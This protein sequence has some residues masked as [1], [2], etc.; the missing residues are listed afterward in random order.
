[1]QSTRQPAPTEE[2]K[3]SVTA[4]AVTFA[5]MRAMD[6]DYG[7]MFSRDELELS[8]HFFL[9]AKQSL[10]F[11]LNKGLIYGLSETPYRAQQFFC[12]YIAIVRGYDPM[13][14]LRKLMIKQKI[15]SAIANGVKQ[16]VFLG[17]GYDTRSLLASLAHPDINFYEMDRGLTRE[18]KI[19]GFSSL[20]ATSPANVKM[21]Y[22]P[23]QSLVK[24]NHNLF[25]IDCD[26]AVK[27]LRESLCQNGFRPELKTLM[28]AEG[29]TTYLTREANQKMLTS[30]HD[31]FKEGDELL[32][33]YMSRIADSWIQR[34]VLR[35]SNE[36][37]FF[38]LKPEQVI[39]FVASLG[40]DVTQRFVATDHLGAIGETRDQAY[41]DYYPD[42]P[43]EHYYLLTRP[44]VRPDG[45]KKIEDVPKMEMPPL[46]RPLEPSV[47][48]CQVL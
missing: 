28:I 4:L 16:V 25:L 8:K 18:T 12:H 24:I 41:Y 36:H 19:R 29:L 32:L 9:T 1:M 2:I 3:Q 35:R 46:A 27:D 38:P 31:L 10:P 30:I 15:E 37:Y 45:G 26:L 20:P 47:S 43:R 48:S 44:T 40:L 23:A 13:I 6:T 7:W 22:I 21:T 11:G 5:F 34:V 14:L 39:P 42:E 17:G 33:S